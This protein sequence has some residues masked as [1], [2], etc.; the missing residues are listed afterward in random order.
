MSPSSHAANSQT[1]SLVAPPSHAAPGAP[2]PPFG[3]SWEGAACLVS[4]GVNTAAGPAGASS[5]PGSQVSAVTVGV[6]PKSPSLCLLHS[7]SLAL[8]WRSPPAAG[9]PSPTATGSPE[10]GRDP[11][12]LLSVTAGRGSA[13]LCPRWMRESSRGSRGSGEGRLGRGPPSRGASNGTG[14]P[15][16][17]RVDRNTAAPFLEV[18]AGRSRM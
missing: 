2:A 16:P 3:W 14:A 10:H 8:S 7:G 6:F 5:G 11:A 4:T 9:R 18:H 13:S 12:G 15:T 1:R 17:L